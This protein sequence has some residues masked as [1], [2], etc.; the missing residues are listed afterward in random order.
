[1]V[2]A[3]EQE[4]VEEHGADVQLKVHEGVDH[5]FFNDARPEVYDPAAS[6]T[7]WRETVAFLRGAV[8]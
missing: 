2:R 6:A 4:L 5:A 7:A 3:L 8:H 1:M